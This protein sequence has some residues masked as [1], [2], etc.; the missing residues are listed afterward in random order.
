MGS[1]ETRLHSSAPIF[2][3]PFLSN[4]KLD[5][6]LT[7][8]RSSAFIPATALGHKHLIPLRCCLLVYVLEQQRVC[9]LHQRKSIGS[10]DL[11]SPARSRPTLTRFPRGFWVSSWLRLFLSLDS[12]LFAVPLLPLATTPTTPFLHDVK[13]GE[14]P[15]VRLVQQP[16]LSSQVAAVEP[17]SVAHQKGTHVHFFVPSPRLLLACAPRALLPSRKL[18][19]SINTYHTQLRIS[20]NVGPQLAFYSACLVFRLPG[21]T[22]RCF[23]VNHVVS[24]RAC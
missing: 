10:V 13:H 5:T 15:H 9:D 6:T 18:P 24:L 3:P 11:A 17:L 20:I 7:T 4:L 22:R 1:F 12:Q 2:R 16:A 23:P 21:S 8:N 14:L 19:T